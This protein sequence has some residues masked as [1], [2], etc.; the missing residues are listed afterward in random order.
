M[1]LR[2][3]TRRGRPS[4]RD[5]SLAPESLKA[6]LALPRTRTVKFEGKLQVI[7]RIQR[8]AVQAR[9][10]A[11]TYLETTPF[12]QAEDGSLLRTTPDYGKSRPLR[13]DDGI[14]FTMTGSRFLAERVAPA[15]LAALG[16]EPA[17][18]P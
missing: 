9:A 4:R 7:R 10:P 1:H 13:A 12:L 16:L 3:S 14:H 6:W 8:E 18:K 17:A 5:P 2:N 11:A 15:V